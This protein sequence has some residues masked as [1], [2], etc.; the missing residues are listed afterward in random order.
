MIVYGT[1]VINTAIHASPDC[2]RLAQAVNPVQEIDLATLQAPRPCRACFPEFPDVR[3]VHARCP[4][5]N[6]GKVYPCAHNG[7]VRVIVPGKTMRTKYVW[8]ENAHRYDLAPVA[9]RV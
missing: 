8:P 3:V 9:I 5:C 6:R 1:G 2:Y 4:R 7:G